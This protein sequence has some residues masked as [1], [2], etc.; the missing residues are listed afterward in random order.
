MLRKLGI[1]GLGVPLIAIIAALVYLFLF[2]TSEPTFDVATRELARDHTV[3]R[4]RD[5]P[6]TALI[7]PTEPPES[8][9]LVFVLRDDERHVWAATQDL[10][11]LDY[12][13]SHELAVI[14]VAGPADS[15]QLNELA[16]LAIEFVPLRRIYL[17]GFGGS[18]ISDFCDARLE[19]DWAGV[20]VVETGATTE[21]ERCGDL[22]IWKIEDENEAGARI[23]QLMLESR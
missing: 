2:G 23:V 5:E 21:V 12:V 11:L 1:V 10:G 9:V 19:V 14:P 22:P 13:D 3:L 4:I 20:I 7:V 16:A 15:N 6:P 8:V 18:P 17:V